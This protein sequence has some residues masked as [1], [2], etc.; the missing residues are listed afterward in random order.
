MMK[1]I[2]SFFLLC[3][4]LLSGC[5]NNT[6]EPEKPVKTA[7]YE[8]PPYMRLQGYQLADR[9]FFH[10]PDQT[11]GDVYTTYY[12]N[13]IQELFGLTPVKPQWVGEALPDTNTDLGLLLYQLK[14]YNFSSKQLAQIKKDLPTN[15][16]YLS[17]QKNAYPYGAYMALSLEK[18][19]ALPHSKEILS[20]LAAPSLPHDESGPMD[21]FSILELYHRMQKEFSC[22]I[23]LPTV[24]AAMQQAYLAELQ[25]R[26]QSKKLF[27]PDIFTYFN[28]CLS[29]P[30]LAQLDQELFD[31]MDA[32]KAEPLGWGGSIP[33][34]GAPVADI[35]STYQCLS[36][37]KGNQ[38]PTPTQQ[39]IALW[40]ARYQCSNGLFAPVSAPNSQFLASS[41]GLLSLH[42]M[43][44]GEDIGIEDYLRPAPTPPSLLNAYQ[45]WLKQL[46]G[47]DI[48]ADI[49]L[50]LDEFIQRDYAQNQS[51]FPSIRALRLEKLVLV[52]DMA[53]QRNIELTSKEKEQIVGILQTYYQDKFAPEKYCKQLLLHR[54]TGETP[55]DAEAFFADA[56]TYLKTEQSD[57]LPDGAYVLAIIISQSDELKKAVPL[58]YTKAMESLLEESKTPLGLYG[59]KPELGPETQLDIIYFYTAIETLLQEDFAEPLWQ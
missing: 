22:Q 7:F 48:S 47:L 9:G 6:P 35:Q 38:R 59:K 58:E 45:L 43:K 21:F 25:A 36:I 11:T 26:L 4:L 49:P 34:Y 30:D 31:Y 37:L 32:L 44:P 50:L 2:A 46:A 57:T 53:Q 28:L 42:L 1:R 16:A 54:L 27:S 3:C 29:Y 13:E 56:L 14:S 24:T 15:G 51:I 39:E 8:V 10:T 19:L 20:Q 33:P 52:L 40:L 18:Q 23:E 17:V 5:Q 55:I 41:Y 12:A